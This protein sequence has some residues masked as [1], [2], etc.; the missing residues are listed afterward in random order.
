MATTNTDAFNRITSGLQVQPD[1]LVEKQKFGG[2][3]PEALYAQKPQLFRKGESG[4]PMGRR[5]GA[6][7]RE[8]VRQIAERLNFNPIEAAIGLIREDKKVKRML[9]ITDPVP[10][11]TKV[12]LLTFVGDKIY[13]SLKAVDMTIADG[14]SENKPRTVQLYLPEKGSIEKQKQPPVSQSRVIEQETE[15]D[16][17]RLEL[18]MDLANAVQAGDP[19]K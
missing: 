11:A 15:R 9:R 8:T 19:V 5:V 13:A 14:E 17:V 16:T 10:M 12:K 6:K 1:P 7:N 18:T 2:K 3:D 4:N